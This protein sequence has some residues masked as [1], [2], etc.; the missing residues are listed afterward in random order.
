MTVVEVN[1]ISN[2]RKAKK[3]SVK[4]WFPLDFIR[5]QAFCIAGRLSD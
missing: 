4:G 2:I 5:C 1:N 3:L